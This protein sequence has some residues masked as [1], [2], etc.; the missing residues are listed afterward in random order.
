MTDLSKT[1]QQKTDLE[2]IKDNPDTYI[3]SIELVDDDLWIQDGSKIVLKN[4]KY[5]PALA[6]LFDE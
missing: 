5:I 4:I 6:K 2:H 3:G 1:Y